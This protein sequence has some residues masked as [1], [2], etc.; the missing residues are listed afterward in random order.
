MVK[1]R[2][3]RGGGEWSGCQGTVVD[4]Q[5]RF[6]G[7]VGEGSSFYMPPAVQQTTSTAQRS[8]CCFEASRPR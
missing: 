6:V 7:K 2:C 5:S 1:G 4:K 8:M 3:R